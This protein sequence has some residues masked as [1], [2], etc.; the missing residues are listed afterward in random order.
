VE[1]L[2]ALDSPVVTRALGAIPSI[3]GTS[4]Q[5]DDIVRPYA[6]H[7]GFSSQRT[8]LFSEYPVG[9]R[10]DWY[11]KLGRSGI[12]FEVERGKAVTNNMDLLDL[13]KCHICREAEHLI[14]MVPIAVSRSYGVE[15]VY[16]RVATRLATFFAP[17]SETNVYSTAILGY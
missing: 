17:G 6:E 4:H 16:G 12:I 7:Y 13:W 1:L 11:R 14:L 15:N 3:G 8:T 9:L 5:V 10:P 2:A